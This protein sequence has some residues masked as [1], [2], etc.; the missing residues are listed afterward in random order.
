[1]KTPKLKAKLKKNKFRS[2]EMKNKFVFIFLIF[3]MFDLEYLGI[4]VS[5]HH[6]IFRLHFFS[7]MGLLDSLKI[8]I[9]KKSI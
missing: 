6:L 5:L 8:N 1:M 7:L 2:E 4:M 3:L 9:L